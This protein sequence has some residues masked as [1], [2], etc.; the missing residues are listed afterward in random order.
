MPVTMSDFLNPGRSP[1]HGCSRILPS[2]PT[3]MK[4]RILLVDDHDI[5][6]EGLRLMIQREADLEVVGEA[7]DSVTAMEQAQRLSPDLVVMD[8]QLG[9]GDGIETSRQMLIQSPTLRILILSAL[10]EPSVV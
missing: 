1:K 9:D 10:S 4:T 3:Q 8:V 6:R 7:G 5:M 2:D